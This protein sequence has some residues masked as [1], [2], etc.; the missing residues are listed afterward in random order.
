MSDETK[1]DETKPDQLATTEDEA[2]SPLK[3]VT[4]FLSR[5]DLPDS[6]IPNAVKAF[7]RLC[8]A[9]IEWP[10]AYLKGK[11][12]ESQT[13]TEAR[14]KITENIAT[15]I[16]QQMKVDPEYARRAVKKYG[17]KI[18][19][20]QVNLDEI[21]A[22]AANELN[23]AESES[24]TDQSTNAEN[25]EE[26]TIN[27]DWLN[28]FE[29]EARQK[30]TEEMQL[31][32]GRILAGEI[33]KPGTYSI[34]TVKILGGLDQNV[35]ILFQKLCSICVVH[36]DLDVKKEIFDA[37]VSPLGGNPGQNALRKY[38][39]GFDQLNILNEYGLIISSYDSWYEYNLL[40]RLSENI[41]IAFL[42]WHQGRYW[43][44]HT[45][46]GWN[47]NK[48]KFKLSGVALSHVGCELFPIVDQEPMAQYTEE[49]KKFFAGQHLQMVEV[50]NQTKHNPPTHTD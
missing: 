15:Q 28:S 47:V 38:G 22:I 7:G 42:L 10:V 20:E 29:E 36:G 11:A 14:I 24:S 12:A 40:P 33:R 2:G 25:A 41:L 9:G 43:T 27:D 3:V 32:F 23:K 46:P 1:P 4:D 44:L 21:S 39:L 6:I 19:R 34:R 17:Q 13:R 5:L 45:L 49:L 48:R 16:D 35:A 31:L 37:R 50:H 26:Q 30:S 8:T 18:L